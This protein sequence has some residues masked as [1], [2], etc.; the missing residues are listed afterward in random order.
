M[1]H[2]HGVVPRADASAVPTA[3]VA[4]GEPG[5]PSARRGE[6][7]EAAYRYVLQHGLGE[8]S[9]RPLAAAIDS[10]PRVLL[11]LFDSKNGLVRALLE[12]ARAEELDLLREVTSPPTGA[13]LMVCVRAAVRA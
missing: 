3:Q 12:R 2:Y 11:Y 1:F 7:L 13:C 6:L 9:L 5:T 8:M 10:S 4:P